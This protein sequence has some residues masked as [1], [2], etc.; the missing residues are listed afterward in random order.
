[1][2]LLE[3]LI[4]TSQIQFVCLLAMRVLLIHGLG[5]TPLSLRPLAYYLRQRGH[6]TESLGYVAAVETFA[7]I[8]DRLQARMI[9]MAS[10]G[11]RF[12]LCGHALGGLLALS[13]LSK[14]RIQPG[15]A[16]ALITLGTPLTPPRLAQRFKESPWFRLAAGDGSHRLADPQF[17]TALQAPPVPWLRIVGT[18]GPTGQLSPF[19]GEPNDG[20]VGL[21][22][23]A[24]EGAAPTILVDAVHT[25]LMNSTIA[26]HAIEDFLR[27]TDSTMQ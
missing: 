5:G 22:E 17:F 11:Q 1:M 4:E 7:S 2:S 14:V 15:G 13:A 20:V 19:S 10:G 16:S 23:A 6:L 12:A 21:D 25:F 24:W 18:G 9:A 3:T 26:R 27:R 8:C